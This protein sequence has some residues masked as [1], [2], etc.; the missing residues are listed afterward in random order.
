MSSATISHVQLAAAHDG[1][2]ELIVTLTFENGGKSL[3]TLDE[4]AAQH[5]MSSTGRNKPEELNGT[6]WEFVRD[7]LAASSARYQTEII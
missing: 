3:V 6:G 1:I 7:A 5:L 2:A 4:C